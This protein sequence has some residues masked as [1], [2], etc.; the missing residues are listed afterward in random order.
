MK[1]QALTLAIAFGLAGCFMADA[2]P[3]KLGLREVAQ[4]DGTT[5]RA[6]LAGD[7]NFHYYLS[8]DGLPLFPDATGALRYVRLGATGEVEFSPM[9]AESSP[10]RRSAAARSYVSGVDPEAVV[11][12]LYRYVSLRPGVRRSALAQ[13][14]LGRFS[15]NFPRVGDIPALVFLVEYK[16]VKFTHPNPAQYFGDMINKEGFSE[17]GG[18]GCAREYFIQQSGGK[19]RPQFEVY[20]PVTLPENRSYYGGN[21]MY[22][23]DR[24]PEQMLVDAAKLL[25]SEVDFSKYDLDNDGYVDNVFIFYAGQGEASYGSAET[26]WPHSY[27]LEVVGKAIKLDGKTLSRYACTNEWEQNRPDGVGTFIHEFSHVMGL[28]DLYRTTGSAYYTPDSWSVLD[29]GPYNNDGCTPPNYS[30]FERNAMGWIEPRLLDGPAGINLEEIGASND[31]CIIQTEKET[32]F[33]LLEN[34]QQ[35]GW[36]KYLPGHGMLIWHVDFVQSV[37]NRNTV[38]NT[39]SHQYVDL[40]E[41]GGVANSS[42]EDNLRTYPWPGTRNKTSFTSTT[43]PA[44]KS[45]AGRAIDV[46]ITEIFEDAD[47]V[48]SFKVC[49]GPIDLGVPQGLRGEGREDGAALLSWEP[50]EFAK[51]YLI[52]LYTEAEDGSKIYALREA[53]VEGTEYRVENLQSEALYRFTVTAASGQARGETSGEASFVMP[54]L[55]WEY[56]SPQILPESSVSRNSFTANW[57]KVPG[58]VAYLLDVDAVISG[59]TKVETLDFGKGSTLT[60]PEGWDWSGGNSDL[61]GSNSLGYYGDSAPSLKFSTTGRSLTSPVYTYSIDRI[62][63][64][65]RTA[66]GSLATPNTLSVQGRESA[67]SEWS[68][69][70]NITLGTATT[71][72]DVVIDEIPET[73]RQV[74]FV[75]TKNR[76]NLAFD[77]L[78]L[79]TQTT[80]TK[81]VADFKEKNVG[82]TDSFIVDL[83]TVPDAVAVN[84][85]VKAVNAEGKHSQ[86][87]KVHTVVPGQISGVSAPGAEPSGLRLSGRELSFE[88]SAGDAVRVFNAA[89]MLVASATADASGRASLRFP[90]PGLYIVAVPD[91]AARMMVR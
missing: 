67:G 12:A 77:D 24:N 74:R 33:Y 9:K 11:D 29:Y 41:A 88:G 70:K 91:G 79:T 16:D 50:V 28:P 22:G 85:S 46:P 25:D 48:I 55:A 38:N 82:D 62:E 27:E 47:G 45:W 1:K 19:F 43:S 54:A 17:Y 8:E 57:T 5:I 69:I 42:Y 76:G 37:W 20:G 31:G 73:V 83:S 23:N 61:Y 34:R 4:P 36:D 65:Y 60:F 3:A 40:I 7:E 87:S 84:Y 89:G 72:E 18:T 10:L 39:Q 58:A 14:G 30:I 64:W 35:V 21:D 66:S 52:D 49:G 71:G 15:G 80:A 78:K 68:V 90:A 44:L 6:E 56:M 51:T 63:F 26:V 32:E 86:A 2:V 13:S 81:T 75:F 59:G 53:E